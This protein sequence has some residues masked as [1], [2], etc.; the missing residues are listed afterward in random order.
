MSNNIESL[1]LT[2]EALIG[3]GATV[4]L[5]SDRYACTVVDFDEVKKII[6][7]QSDNAKRTDFNGMSDCQSYDYS[8]DE[9]GRYFRFKIKDEEWREAYVNE[10]GNFVLRKPSD[11][12]KLAVGFRRQYYDFSF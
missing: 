5:F 9:N 8:T 6:T 7:V 3:T 10:K 2:K 12:K 11:S 1:T 4:F